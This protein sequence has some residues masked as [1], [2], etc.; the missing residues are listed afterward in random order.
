MA[1]TATPATKAGLKTLRA[2][3]LVAFVVLAVLSWRAYKMAP[4][5]IDHGGDWQIT[6]CVMPDGSEW[7]P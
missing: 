7:S 4:G 5:C 6:K 3:L 2:V 1:V